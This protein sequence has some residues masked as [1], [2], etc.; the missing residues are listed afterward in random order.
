M[1]FLPKAA[2][3]FVCL[4]GVSSGT[5]TAADLQARTSRAY[6]AYLEQAKRA[7]LS[8]VRSDGA[9]APERRSGVFAKPGREDG[10]VEVPDGLVHHWIGR[11][12]VQGAT[13]RQVVD[14]SS[15]HSA[16]SVMYKSIIASTVLERERDTY[17]VLMRL[18]EAEAGVSAVLEIRSTIQY[19]H[20][21]SGSVY[22]LSN[23]DE[24]REVKNAGNRD[25][26]LLPAGRDSGY[27]WRAN[28]FTHFLEQK[29]GVFV[30]M[31]TL[32][33]S[34][35]FPPFLGWIIEPI[36]RR[37]GRKSVETSLQEFLTAVRT[38]GTPQPAVSHDRPARL[39][40]QRAS[41]PFH[42]SLEFLRHCPEVKLV[43]ATFEAAHRHCLV[44]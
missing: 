26:R 19:F 23:A 22:A 12:F 3:V 36:A 18:K 10:I 42:F 6:D 34:R 30:E 11:A 28:T 15:A 4:G 1:R 5:A 39:H 27:L 32:G 41:A 29:D 43:L 31:E 37:L 33:L 25:E 13:L 9:A 8:R 7:F 2:L 17:R 21:T 40:A 16:Y 44:G 38:A 14:V 24:I 35:R 20:S